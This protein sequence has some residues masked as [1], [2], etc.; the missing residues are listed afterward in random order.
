MLAITPLDGLHLLKEGDDLAGLIVERAKKLGVGIRN[1]D[2][3]VVVVKAVYKT[4]GRIVD[5]DNIRL[6]TRV[7]GIALK[8]VKGTDSVDSGLR[9]LSYVM[10][11]DGDAL[12]GAT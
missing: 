10:R 1:R 8:I 11:E 4:D 7:A 12:T 3:L 6:S 5:I 2:V 9:E